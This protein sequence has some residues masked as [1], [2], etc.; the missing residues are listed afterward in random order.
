MRAAT[1]DL[2]LVRLVVEPTCDLFTLARP[3]LPELGD[4]RAC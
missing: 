4:R 2:T 1:T 3:G